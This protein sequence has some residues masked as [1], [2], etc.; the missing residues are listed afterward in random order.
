[1]KRKFFSF[2]LVSFLPKIKKKA[3]SELNNHE[4]M[5]SRVEYGWAAAKIHWSFLCRADIATHTTLLSP[6]VCV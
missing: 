4:E 1:M 3:F 5:C 2:F 6:C